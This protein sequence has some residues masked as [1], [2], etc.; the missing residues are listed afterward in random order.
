M[1][2]C[3]GVSPLWLAPATYART[4]PSWIAAGSAAKTSAWSRTSL[5]KSEP[6][7]LS[8]TT[9]ASTSDANADPSS[10]RALSATAPP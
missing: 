2:D 3:S 8:A 1:S 6:H 5:K 10:S 4:T 7:G 9:S